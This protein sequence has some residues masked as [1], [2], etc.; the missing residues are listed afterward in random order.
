MNTRDED[1]LTV[2]Q[3]AEDGT[4]TVAILKTTLDRKEMRKRERIELM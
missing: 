3:Q 4:S 2:R 1:T